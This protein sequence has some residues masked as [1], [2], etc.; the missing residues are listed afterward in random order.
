[1]TPRCRWL[2]GLGCWTLSVL[3]APD[4]WKSI[5]A[6]TPSTAYAAAELGVRPVDVRVAE[7][8]GDPK[9]WPVK[10]TARRTRR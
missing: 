8:P 9:A 5:G 3:V 4:T 1:M 7:N 10:E 2:L 6:D